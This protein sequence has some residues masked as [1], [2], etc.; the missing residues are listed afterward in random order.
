[1]AGS[2]KELLD[3][4]ANK[5]EQYKA[6]IDGAEA[7]NKGTAAGGTLSAEDRG[8]LD[9]L[10]AE[11]DKLGSE[12]DGFKAAERHKDR[13]AS[14]AELS[15][16]PVGRQTVSS[17]PGL[18]PTPDAATAAAVFELKGRKLSFAPGTQEHVR[19]QPAYRDSFNKYLGGGN[20]EQLGLQVASDPK[21]GYIAPTTWVAELIKFLDDLVFIRQLATVIPMPG[22]VSIGAPSWDTDPG[23]ADW[24]AEVPA[25]D[26][27]EDDTATMGRR[28]LVPHLLTK[29]V[30]MSMKLLRSNTLISPDTLL[31]Q[32]LAY[33]F[34]ITEEKAFMTGAG[35]QRPLGVYTASA[36][37]ISTGRDVSAASTMTFTAD[38]L[39]NTLFSLKAAY[40]ARSTW[41]IHRDV[42][43]TVRK[44]KDGNGQYL[45]VP[46]IVGTDNDRILG[47][48]Y[49]MSEYAPNTFTTGLY[50]A[51]VGDFSFYWI[52]DSW[53]M[54]VQRLNELF[55][56]R[57]QVGM[58]GR[59]ETDG[60]PV[61]E[62][63]FA[64]LK[65]A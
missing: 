19:S 4:R 50:M 12:I 48:P 21:G 6:I 25:A 31:A 33:K 20:A 24:T 58:L 14:F 43:K 22:A 1:M 55:S 36:Q 45:W 60:M 59:K 30:K 3:T 51:C 8:C 27:S 7:R 61:L 28:E 41:L 40:Q 13:L 23:D 38:E 63:A 56:L 52:A 64:R 42:V 29:L 15:K 44:L 10:D 39:I 62:E 26:I 32:R 2:L 37:G 35:N 47:R 53:A 54:E 9:K 46:G 49:V 34:G 65:L 5:F 16:E 57:N 18:S 17:S 11:I